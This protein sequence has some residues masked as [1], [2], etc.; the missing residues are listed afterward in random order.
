MKVQEKDWEKCRKYSSQGRVLT[1]RT[2]Q[3]NEW[4]L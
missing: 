2:R 4:V 3:F 1:V